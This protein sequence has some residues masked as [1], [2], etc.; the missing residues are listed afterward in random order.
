MPY[1]TD[2]FQGDLLYD[3]AA[4]PVIRKKYPDLVVKDA[5]DYIHPD[6]VEIE[7]PD[8]TNEEF[9]KFAI[10]EGFA[11]V[12]LGFNIQIM[13]DKEFGEAMVAY[14]KSLKAVR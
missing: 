5:R 8:V 6:R 1:L 7:I 12:L 4:L 13:R 10:E 3:D 9:Y 14:A 11:S 2:P